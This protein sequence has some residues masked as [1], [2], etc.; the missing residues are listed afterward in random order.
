[1]QAPAALKRR[2]LSGRVGAGIDPCMALQCAMELQPGEERTI[3][4][5]LGEG[6]D[7]EQARYLAGKYRSLEQVEV[8]YQGTLRMW[9]WLL[10]AVV[11]ETPDV[12]MNMLLNRWA[13]YQSISC[14]LW[15]RTAFYQSGGA[16]G[17]R[18]QL[19]DVM[20]LMYTAPNLAREQI[21]RCEERQF[22][23][24]DVQHWWHPPTGRGVRT[25]FSDDLLWLP[26]VT[27]HY[28]A[29]TGDLG[30][31]DEERPYLQAPLLAPDQEDMYSTPTVSEE[32]GTLY[33][34]CLRAIKRGVTAG[35]HGLPLMGSGD[36]NDGMNR[37]GIEG[38]GESVWLGWFLYAVLDKFSP[39]CEQRGD[40]EHAAEF[41]AEMERLK[42]ALERE[43]WDGE[44]YLRAFY[45]NGTPLGSAQSEECQIDAIAQSWGV[46]SGAAEEARAAQ[47]MKSLEE[48]LVLEQD[49]LILLL[50]PPFDKTPEDPGYI[51]GYL[52]GV[53]ENGGQYTHAS[54]WVAI[55]RVLLGDGE[56]AYRLFQMLNPVN[57]AI[58]EDEVE[59]YKVEPYVIAADIY[60]HPQHIGRGGWTWY[61][62]SASWFYRLGVEYILGLKLHGEHFTVEPCVPAHWPGYSMTLR[63]RDSHYHISVDGG[64]GTEREVT[65][66][67]L[68]GSPLP[69][70]KVPLIDDG[71]RHEVRVLLGSTE[72]VGS[73]SS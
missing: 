50:T 11:V 55:A 10:S 42:E 39:I 48:R 8:E 9:D 22:V 34:H 37:V 52:P 18:D 7:L 28:I 5:T 21:V 41:R 33:E 66:V 36:W 31:L 45:D 57:H 32:V 29:A 62:G 60:S 67:E 69:E 14:R 2:E 26:F 49:Q 13:L 40:D 35:A 65:A 1:M 6:D 15:G 16:Y 25:R 70:C 27:A 20:A 4:F 58:T 54:I 61:T 56:G 59:R 43:A 24:G 30:V 44:W 38:K 19:Q 46:I 63:Y 53:R 71:N 68:D 17:Y 64:S 51:K 72:R 47:A 3:V 23:E 12:G 73:A